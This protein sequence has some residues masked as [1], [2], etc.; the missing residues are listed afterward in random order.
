[1]YVPDYVE[2]ANHVIRSRKLLPNEVRIDVAGKTKEEVF[3]EAINIID[4]FKPLIDYK[5]ELDNEHNYLSW[6][7]SRQLY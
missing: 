5:Y 7:Q 3:N 4:N 2:R 1:M 6:V